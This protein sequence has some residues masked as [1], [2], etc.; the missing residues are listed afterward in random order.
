[1]AS[2]VKDLT[3]TAAA[4]ARNIQAAQQAARD[5]SAAIAASKGRTVPPGPAEA[6]AVD[7]GDQ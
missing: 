7:G 2:T 5:T 3:K 6:Q 1:M 4:A